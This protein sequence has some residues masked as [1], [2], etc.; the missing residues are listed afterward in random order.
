MKIA[1]CDKLGLCY[2][3]DTLN[4]RGLGGSESAVI[5]MSRELSKLGFEVTVFNNCE[6]SSYSGEGIFDDGVRYIDNKNAPMHQENYDITIVSRTVHPFIDDNIYPFIKN[7]KLKVLWLHD[8]FCEGDEYLEDLVVN[9][10]IDYVFTLSDFHTNY[11]LT[12]DHGKKRMYEVLK[13]SVFQTRNGAVKYFDDVDIFKKDRNHFV[14]NASLTKGLIPLL[15]EI[16][17][18]IKTQIPDA[19]L[20]VIG[21]YYKF[22]EYSELDEQGKK[23]KEL[24]KN[25]KYKNLDVTFTDV[26]PQK[27]VAEILKYA[28]FMLYP[29]IFPETSGISSLESLLYKTPIITNTFGALEE[30]AISQACYKLDYP[31]EPNVLYP[32]INK[33]LQIDKFV[34]LVIDAYNDP[35][36]YQQKCNYCSVIEDI[37]GWDNIALEWKRFFYNKLEKFLPVEDY[38]KTKSIS[39]KTERIFGRV[40]RMPNYKEFQSFGSENKITVISPFYNA[41][42][43]IEKC[44]LSVAQQD[45]ENYHHILINDCSTDNS[46]NI[47][48]NTISKLPES[49]QSKF[50]VYNNNVNKGALY[51]QITAIREFTEEDDIIM[52]LDGDDWL[53]NNNTIFHLYND[54]Y[55]SGTEF[56]YGSCWSIADNIPLIAQEYPT[57]IK[58]SKKYRDYKFNWGIPYTHLRTF[59]KSLFDK[60]STLDGFKDE[61]GNYYRAGGDNA[62]FYEILEQANPENVYAIKEVVYNYNDLNPLNDYKVNGN[63]QNMNASKITKNNKKILIAIPTDKYVEA[64]TFKSIYDLEI[65]EGYD[66][67]FQFFYGYNVAQIR[68]LIAE[69]AK[70]YDYLFSV[71]SDIVLPSDSLK[72]MLNSNKDIISGLYIQRI[73]NTHTLEIYMDNENGGMNNIPYELIKNNGISEIAGCG[74]GCCL[75]KSEVF[76]N[77]EYPHFEYHSA[78]YHENTISEDIDFCMKARK[79]G[80]RIWAD[81]SI[82]CDHIGKTKFIV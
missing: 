72:K 3:G 56:T 24:I 58:N 36:L 53:I 11:I 10:N 9:K 63:E 34:N 81:P 46:L 62:M 43:Y 39:N 37:T 78:L 48:N 17:P 76:K 33:N 2:D 15:E 18:K 20:T 14:Y 21:G 51:N 64:E 77:M 12:C 4:N 74:M 32:E 40:S 22:R 26:I 30:T 57:Y 66:T 35:Y 5:L 75:I 29:N 61:W 80:F 8:T 82:I 19:R 31:V 16:W 41:E 69:W 6:D 38:R 59:K 13:H 42:D 7:S 68:N 65:P 70:H 60:L 25:P 1:I 50:S 47:A 73:P 23:L 52:L 67:E 79:C 49:L 27:Q 54:Y 28:G 55:K 44:I 45:Y 71:D